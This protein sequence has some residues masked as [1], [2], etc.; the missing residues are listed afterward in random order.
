[1][2]N[3]RGSPMTNEQARMLLEAIAQITEM[4][5]DTKEAAERIR[6][7]AKKREKPREA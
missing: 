6:E 5:K 7:I 4:S 1:M 2:K 3:K